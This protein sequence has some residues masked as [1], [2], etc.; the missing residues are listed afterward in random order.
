MKASQ[1]FNAP[2]PTSRGSG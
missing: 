2:Y 1:L